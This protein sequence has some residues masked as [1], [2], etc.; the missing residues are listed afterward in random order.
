MWKMEEETW[1]RS[2]FFYV[3]EPQ[4]MLWDSC[5]PSHKN[6]DRRKH[7]LLQPVTQCFDFC[8]VPWHVHELLCTWCW[9]WNI[10]VCF[11]IWSLVKGRS[12]CSR[13]WTTLPSPVPWSRSSSPNMWVDTCKLHTNMLVFVII[14]IFTMYSVLSNVLQETDLLINCV[15][16]AFTCIVYRHRFRIWCF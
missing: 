1:D 10:V 2:G 13:W 14:F 11:S 9:R 5:D 3:W 12:L 15:Y 4:Q 7:E 6:R 8:A 16:I